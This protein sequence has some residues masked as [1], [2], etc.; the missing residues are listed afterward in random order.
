MYGWP[1][2]NHRISLREAKLKEFR[3]RKT[4]MNPYDKMRLLENSSDEEKEKLEKL[5]KNVNFENC[6]N[7]TLSHDRHFGLYGNRVKDFPNEY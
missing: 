5:A 3:V 6:A 7:F 4:L 2:N 1:E